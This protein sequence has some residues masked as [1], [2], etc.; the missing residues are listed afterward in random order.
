MREY[1]Y[2]I[3]GF[4]PRTDISMGR[5]GFGIRMDTQ[6]AWQLKQL[7]LRDEWEER[8]VEIG[9]DAVKA[10]L[11]HDFKPM[12]DTPR[13][14]FWENTCLLTNLSVPGN[15]CGLDMDWRDFDHLQADAE[16]DANYGITW[17]PHNVDSWWQALS[18]LQVWLAWYD[19][20]CGMIH[21]YENESKQKGQDGKE[22]H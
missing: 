2:R 7:P 15:A 21:H 5:W 14:H 4:C 10:T 18:L 3:E 9:T 17:L 6:Y 20:T 16:R 13:L 11:L 22:N 1:H 12:F 19:L 8:I